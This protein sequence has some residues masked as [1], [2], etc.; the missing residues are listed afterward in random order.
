MNLIAEI[1][2]E[3]GKCDKTLCLNH[4]GKMRTGA[5]GRLTKNLCKGCYTKDVVLK[6]SCYVRNNRDIN[7]RNVREIILQEL[8]T[9]M[10]GTNLNNLHIIRLM[11]HYGLN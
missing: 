9:L 2:G 7:T 10:T 1:L 4:A 5:E 3:A 8:M 11:D 6:L